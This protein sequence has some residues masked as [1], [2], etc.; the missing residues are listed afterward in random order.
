MAGQAWRACVPGPRKQHTPTAW[1]FS[2]LVL[3]LALYVIDALEIAPG[4]DWQSLV[5]QSGTLEEGGEIRFLAGIYYGACNVDIIRDL[6]LV[7][8]SGPS[9]S[10]ID[11]QRG[12]RHFHVHSNA[13]LTLRGL[14]IRNGNCTSSEGTPNAG[15]CVL[16]APRT[17]LN[18]HNA[19]LQGCSCHEGGAIYAEQSV[20]VLQDVKLQDSA[21]GASGGCILVRESAVSMTG[22]TLSRCTAGLHG[23]GIAAI[24]SQLDMVGVRAEENSA[25]DKG[26]AVYGGYASTVS[27]SGSTLEQNRA[28]EFVGVRQEVGFGG[29]MAVEHGSALSLVDV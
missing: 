24:G 10:I 22:S 20:L 17:R 5:Q 12:S 11:C 9:E 8:D 26:G 27:V 29:A 21:S 15:G 13:T 2:F 16:L 6:T 7:G 25:Y 4:D 1:A 3:Q 18:I 19:V 28:G 23:G 14:T